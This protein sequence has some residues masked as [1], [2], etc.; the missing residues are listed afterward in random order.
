MIAIIDYGAGNITSVKNAL[1]RMGANSVITSENETIQKAQ[2]VIFPGV[3]EASTA[4]RYLRLKKWDKLIP[5]L[6]QPFLGICLGQQLMCAHSEE[7]DTSCLNIFDVAVKKFPPLG[8]VPH[9]GWNSILDNKT[10]LLENIKE[11]SDVYFVHS[12]YCELSEYTIST[13]HYLLDFSAAI[14][15]DNFYATQFHPE[16]SGEIGETLLKNFINL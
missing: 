1:D 9:T 15:K 12:Y 7:G 13:C 8:I 10:S 4:M 16:K 14:Q 11:G 5:Q 2:K 3:G 6:Q